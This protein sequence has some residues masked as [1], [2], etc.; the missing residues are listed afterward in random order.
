MALEGN[1]VTEIY[2]ALSLDDVRSAADNFRPVYDKTDGH[3]AS[4]ASFFV[5][6]IDTLV[7]PLPETHSRG[8][9]AHRLTG[10]C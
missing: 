2:E 9:C 5:S 8:I 1:G 3:V 4:V 6:R 10:F 7:D